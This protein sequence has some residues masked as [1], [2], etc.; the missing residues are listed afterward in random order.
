MTPV[1]AWVDIR[2]FGLSL[3]LIIGVVVVG[4]VAMALALG[5][6]TLLRLAVW[7]ARVRRAQEQ[8]AR[9]RVRDDGQ[10]Y[11]PVDR[12]LCDLCAGAF[13]KVYHLPSG[14]RMCEDCYRRMVQEAHEQAFCAPPG[15]PQAGGEAGT[16]DERARR[17]NGAIGPEGDGRQGV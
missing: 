8:A 4:L 14:Q 6:W 3:Y 15:A 16:D 1:L 9:A 13:E 10:P 2:T 12:G 7:K 17:G 11:P 5:A